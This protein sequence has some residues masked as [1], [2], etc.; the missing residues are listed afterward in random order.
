MEKRVAAL[1]VSDSKK[2]LRIDFDIF[3]GARGRAMLEA[4]VANDPKLMRD[5]FL[6]TLDGAIFEFAFDPDLER[7]STGVSL[8]APPNQAAQP[9]VKTEE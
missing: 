5:W 4:A 8:Q 7:S 3:D 9:A 2:L 1:P 6:N